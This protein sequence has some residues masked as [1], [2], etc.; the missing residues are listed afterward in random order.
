MVMFYSFLPTSTHG[1]YSFMWIDDGCEEVVSDLGRG[2]HH[3]ES[4]T[5]SSVL[6]FCD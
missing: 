4:E 1:Y 3:C 2:A 6:D 5:W